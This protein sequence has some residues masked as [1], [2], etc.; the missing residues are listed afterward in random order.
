MCLL[1]N[2]I[3]F[4][5][6]LLFL[7]SRIRTLWLSFLS[8]HTCS[9]VCYGD[10]TTHVVNA[11]VCV[12]VGLSRDRVMHTQVLMYCT[13]T[14]VSLSLLKAKMPR[15]DWLSECECNLK[16]SNSWGLQSILIG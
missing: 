14:S 6:F 1:E 10:I 8:K 2:A 4:L 3:P 5:S 12:C 15:Y 9:G 7:N 11:C 13:I 16:G